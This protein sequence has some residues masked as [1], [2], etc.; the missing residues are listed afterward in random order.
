MG[1]KITIDGPSASGKGYL[2]HEIS[3]RLEILNVDTGA[4]YRAFGLYCLQNS[5]DLNDESKIASAL[6]E[7]NID[8]NYD[9]DTLKV[10]LNNKDISKDIRTEQVGMLASVV[11]AIPMVRTH[12]VK[13]Q[14][15]IA[16]F[17]N[18]VMEGRDIGSVVF[19]E[20]ELKI[21]LTAS[22]AVR[23]ERRYKD[24]LE[25]NKQV[26]L[27]GV[28]EDIKKRDETDINKAISPLVKTEDMIE[29]DT[30]YLDKEQVIQ[31]VLELV[32]EKGLIK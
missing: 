26:T 7:A 31:K 17:N 27:E 5:I 6:R 10:Y 16:G 9:N 24:L 21:F 2:A 22:D 15:Q 8:F 11:S 23:A 13:L 32:K 28:L 4:M 30:T 18:I 14:R 12:M 1:Y 19:P 25:K 3:K 20:A 29:L